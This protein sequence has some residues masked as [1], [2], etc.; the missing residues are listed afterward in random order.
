MPGMENYA[1]QLTEVSRSRAQLYAKLAALNFIRMAT[2]EAGPAGG[3]LSSWQI[4]R[5]RDST[6]WSR[7][8]VGGASVQPERVEED[9]TPIYDIHGRMLFWD[10]TTPIGQEELRVRSAANEVLGTPVFSLSVQKPFPI[11]QW[12]KEAEQKARSSNLMPVPGAQALVCYSYPK[13]G[14]LC[15]DA[16]GRRLV[17]DLSDGERY[18]VDMLP[19]LEAGSSELAMTWSPFD[20]IHPGIIGSQRQNFE[21]MASAIALPEGADLHS[22]E[23]VTEAVEA[24][25][26]QKVLT[27]IALVGQETPVYCAVATAKMILEYHGLAKTQQEIA[28]AMKTGPYG[29]TSLDQVSGY[30]S[31]GGGDWIASLDQD[32]SFKEAQ[33]EINAG[34]PFKSGI[35]GHARAVAGWKSAAGASDKAKAALLVYDPW[36]VHEGRIYWEFWGATTILNTVTIQRRILA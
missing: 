17:I 26:Q 27:G 31:L 11:A 4:D 3:N 28:D 1:L 13:L 2:L 15:L 14:L 5:F 30:N 25:I 16:E 36:P 6:F 7:D 35:V 9:S 23:A 29:T 33:S 21:K 10:F 18:T 34:R 32:P 22:L 19:G 20:G 8:L 12:L 24:S